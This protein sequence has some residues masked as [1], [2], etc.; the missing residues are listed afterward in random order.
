MKENYKILMLKKLLSSLLFDKYD[1]DFD[2]WD[3]P[4]HG[5]L[6]GAEYGLTV[7]LDPEKVT[8]AGNDYNR[9]VGNLLFTFDERIR[10][11]LSYVSMDVDDLQIEYEFINS[12]EFSDK[13]KQK[14]LKVL[15]LIYDEIP[16]LPKIKSIRVHPRSKSMP[17]F[18]VSLD[19]DFDRHNTASYDKYGNSFITTSN[20]NMKVFDALHTLLPELGD[21]HVQ[22]G[23]Y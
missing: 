6:Y 15:P 3:M 9:S 22:V 16:N 4:Q 12:E 18:E 17:E 8:M 21:I 10:Y 1:I 19:F 7:K 13:L 11:I 14:V 5:Y 23:F 2:I 20:I